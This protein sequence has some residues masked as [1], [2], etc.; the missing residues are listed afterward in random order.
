MEIESLLRQ[1]VEQGASDMFITAGAPPSMKRHGRLEAMQETSLD[2][3]QARQLVL[4]VMTD[5]Q[6]H[7]FE[8]H[9]ECNFAIAS[10]AGR[11]RVSAFAQRN[12]AG[13]VLRPHRNRNP[14]PRRSGP[15]R[16]HQA[17]GHD[18][19]RPGVLRRRHRHRQV[20]QP[21]GHDRPPQSARPGSY[22]FHRGPDR[23]RASAPQQHRYPARGGHRYRELRGGAEEHPCVRR[24]M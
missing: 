12:Q 8:T 17:A 5:E 19:A 1:M 6:R 11:F 10:D 18:Q 13:M 3:E 14:R 24:R 2:T 23:V 4:S 20:D 9:Q 22:H 16:H 7:E 21:G 15:A